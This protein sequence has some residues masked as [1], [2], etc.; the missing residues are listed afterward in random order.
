MSQQNDRTIQLETIYQ[1]WFHWLQDERRLSAHTLKAY[2]HDYSV[3]MGFLQNHFGEEVTIKKIEKLKL[4]DFRSWLA[5]LHGQKLEKRSVA[6]ALS[7]IRNFFSYAAKQ[8]YFKNDAISF[9]QSPKLPQDI[10][11]ALRQDEILESIQSVPFLSEEN[12]LAKRDK[13]ILMLLYGCGLRI[14]ELLDLNWGDLDVETFLRVTGKGQKTRL[15]PLLDNVRQVIKLYQD[16]CPYEQKKAD[17]V[18]YGQRGKR[19][20]ASVVQ[21]KVRELRR[22]LNLP[23]HFT[24]HSFRHS[25]ATHIL[26]EGGD[27]RSIQELLGHASLSTTQKYTSVETQSLLNMYKKLHPREQEE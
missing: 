10:P 14:S 1:D 21:K 17:P 26:A 18:F 16:Y 19:L 9:V 7:V 2:Q 4:R 8:G 12:W 3:F 23:D 20:N 5:Y 24:P 25:Y 6:R 22:W 13:A 27:L 15:V 11:K